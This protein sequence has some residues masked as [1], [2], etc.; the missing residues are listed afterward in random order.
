MSLSHSGKTEL[1][2]EGRDSMGVTGV[3]RV[4]SGERIAGGIKFSPGCEHAEAG[5]CGG[6]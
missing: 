5:R 2:R 6:E 1:T 4:I 3:R